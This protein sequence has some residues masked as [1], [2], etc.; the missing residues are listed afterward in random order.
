MYDVLTHSLEYII[1]YVQYVGYFEL[2]YTT[3]VASNMMYA[4]S[5]EY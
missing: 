4:Y 3:I 2:E 1:M 5:R